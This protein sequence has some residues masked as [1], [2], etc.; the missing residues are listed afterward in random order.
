MSESLST[1]TAAT[2]VNGTDL[3][4][5]TQLGVSKSAQVNQLVSSKQNSATALTT[6]SADR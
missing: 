4:L 6:W 3:L 1:L 5:I 2:G